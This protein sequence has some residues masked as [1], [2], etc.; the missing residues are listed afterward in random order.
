MGR[1]LCRDKVSFYLGKYQG[2]WLLDP[3]G[4][5]M[6]RFVRNCPTVLKTGCGLPPSRRRWVSLHILTRICS[7]QG[8]G[9]WPLWQVCPSVSLLLYLHFPD[10]TLHRTWW[11]PPF[12]ISE[13]ITSKAIHLWLFLSPTGLR[14]EGFLCSPAKISR[15][16]QHVEGLFQ[17]SNVVEICRMSSHF[18]AVLY[19]NL[20]E[21]SLGCPMA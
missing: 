3:H 9:F 18:I 8:P 15:S 4:E 7:C 20:C 19:C 16:S 14:E 10:G 12:F 5:S 11:L 1:F 6:L 2:A 21:F 17:G 13:M